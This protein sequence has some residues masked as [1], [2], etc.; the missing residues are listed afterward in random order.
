MEVIWKSPVARL[1]GWTT[2]GRK[3]L[4]LYASERRYG[5]GIAP[6]CCAKIGSNGEVVVRSIA[7]SALRVLPRRRRILLRG[8]QLLPRGS[9]HGDHRPPEAGDLQLQPGRHAGDPEAQMR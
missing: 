7:I 2:S 4:S 8:G 5:C 1:A 3:P 9:R 6:A